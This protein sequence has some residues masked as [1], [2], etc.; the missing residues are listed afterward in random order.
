MNMKLICK[1]LNLI[2]TCWACITFSFYS[3]ADSKTQKIIKIA[4]G[5]ATAGSY[6]PTALQFC[7]FIEQEMKGTKCQILQTEGSFENI[8]L[9]KNKE[10]DLALVQSD[11]AYNAFNSKYLFQNAEKFNSLNNVLTLFNEDFYTIVRADSEINNFEDFHKDTKIGVANNKSGAIQQFNLIIEQ[12]NKD[13]KQLNILNIPNELLKQKL[14]EGTIDAVILSEATPNNMLHELLDSCEIKVLSFQTA[15]LEKLVSSNPAYYSNK[16]MTGSYPGIKDTIHTLSTKAFLVTHSDSKDKL[17]N[18]VLKAIIDNLDTIKQKHPALA[19][20]NA[21][22]M[23]Q[24]D[25]IP[26]HKAVNKFKSNN[27]PNRE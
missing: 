13:F 4:A 26:Y 6:F 22:E 11:V 17:I 2:L 8:N 3:L 18:D 10:V 15:T 16:I 19:N 24:Q 7:Y 21:Q 25:V 20:L 27:K 12:L 14:C 9:L 1:V 5:E 23:L